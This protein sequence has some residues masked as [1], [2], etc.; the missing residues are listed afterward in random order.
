MRPDR[1]LYE[2]GSAMLSAFLGGGPR[3]RRAFWGDGAMAILIGS[4]SGDAT[5]PGPLTPA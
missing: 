4:L 3:R 5:N 2:Q 1:G